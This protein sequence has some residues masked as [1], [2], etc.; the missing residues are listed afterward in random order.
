MFFMGSFTCSIDCPDGKII[1]S[2]FNTVAGFMR[3]ALND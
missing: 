1:Y 2:S 3:A